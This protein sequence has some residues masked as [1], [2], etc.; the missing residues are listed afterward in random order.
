MNSEIPAPIPGED[1]TSFERQFRLIVFY[2]SLL[3]E[4]NTVRFVTV[5]ADNIKQFFE[6]DLLLVFFMRIPFSV[7]GNVFL[8]S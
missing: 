1:C 3:S 7:C 4:G 8:I 2:R 5:L 6:H